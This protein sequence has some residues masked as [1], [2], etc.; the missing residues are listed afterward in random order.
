MK[1][2]PLPSA[3]DN[4]DSPPMRDGGAIPDSIAPWKAL[5]NSNTMLLITTAALTMKICVAVESATPNQVPAKLITISSVN[6][7]SHGL[8]GPPRSAMA[9]KNGHSNAVM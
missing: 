8:R 2:P 6:S 9:P 5:E 3:K 1:P 4:P 7:A